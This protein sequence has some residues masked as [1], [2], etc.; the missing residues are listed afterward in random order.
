[1]SAP[2]RWNGPSAVGFGEQVAEPG[3]QV[4]SSGGSSEPSTA[5]DAAWIRSAASQMIR[6][7]SSS[8]PPS[9]MRTRSRP[10]VARSSS[11]AVPFA[12]EHAGGAV[13]VECRE[14]V[15]AAD[16]LLGVRELEHRRLAVLGAHGHERAR[17]GR[18]RVAV[19]AQP[20]ASEPGG[21]PGMAGIHGTEVAHDA[22]PHLA[23]PRVVIGLERP[24]AP[25]A[26]PRARAAGS[27][28]CGTRAN[29]SP[30]MPSTSTSAGCSSGTTSGCFAFQ[31]SSASSA[32]GFVFVRATS[33]SGMV[34]CRRPEPS[35][36]LRAASPRVRAP[37]RGA[38]GRR[39]RR[40]RRRF[41]PRGRRARRTARAPWAP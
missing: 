38:A 24:P 4:D 33:I 25:G 16:L 40:R 39:V 15:G 13:P 9:A 37:R 17:G 14:Q 36:R 3:R 30:R 41:P 21:L 20:P 32:S 18:D 31:R 10:P 2:R 26:A 19:G 1:M 5:A 22:V 12:L 11:I 35:R 7:A 23:G 28:G 6:V 29:S 27:R 8:S 34:D